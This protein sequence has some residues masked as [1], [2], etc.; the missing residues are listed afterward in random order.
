MNKRLFFSIGLPDQTK[1]EICFWQKEFRESLER[2]VKW[3]DK[4][5]LHI[6]LLFLGMIKKEKIDDLIKK[7][8][9]VKISPFTVTMNKISYFPENKKRAKMICVEGISPEATELQKKIKNAVSPGFSTV[10][11]K[12]F[13]LHITLGRIK[14]WSFREM[15]IIEIPEINESVDIEFNVDSF[16]LQESRLTNKGAIYTKIKSFKLN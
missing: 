12:S 9:N 8:E 11:D 13:Y 6:T 14:K 10:D 2:G 15:P 5:N 4:D 1:D 7:A 16:N 3:V